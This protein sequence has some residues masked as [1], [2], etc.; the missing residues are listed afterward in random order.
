MEIKEKINEDGCL[1]WEQILWA[2]KRRKEKNKNS[3]FEETRK[4]QYTVTN[5]TGHWS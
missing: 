1:A 5:Q 3:T 4:G 2:E